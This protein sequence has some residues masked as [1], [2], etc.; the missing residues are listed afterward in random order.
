[1]SEEELVKQQLE[2]EFFVLVERGEDIRTYLYLPHTLL[3]ESVRDYLDIFLIEE[4]YKEIEAGNLS[5]TSFI[6]YKDSVIT[7]DLPTKEKRIELLERL[8]NH[9]ISKEEYEKCPKVQ[10]LLNEIQEK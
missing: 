5:A 10:K 1:M 8:I 7:V 3:S 4:A 9:F 2:E 6:V